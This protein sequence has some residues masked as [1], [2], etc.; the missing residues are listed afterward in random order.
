MELLRLAAD[1][2]TDF[3]PTGAVVI[4]FLVL[5]T[6]GIHIWRARAARKGQDGGCADRP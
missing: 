6:L 4:V 5:S 1:E 3:W 2:K